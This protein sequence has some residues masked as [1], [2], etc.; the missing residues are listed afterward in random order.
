MNP[1]IK[2]KLS[3]LIFLFHLKQENIESI[4]R[5]NYN[6]LNEKEGKGKEYN[7][8]DYLIFDGEYAKNQKISGIEYYINE[9]KKYEGEYREN[10]YWNG[11]IFGKLQKKSYEIKLGKG[12]IKEFHENGNLFYEGDINEGIKNGFGKIFDENGHLIYEGN[13]INGIKYGDGKEYNKN[14]DLKY[15]KIK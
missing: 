11:F 1:K 9:T 13:F 14:G 5:G 4:W 8:E 6:K 7:L 2:K 12:K 15:K 3:L 10:K